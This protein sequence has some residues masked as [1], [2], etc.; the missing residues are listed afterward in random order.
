VRPAQA[1]AKFVAECRMPDAPFASSFALAVRREVARRAGVPPQAVHAADRLPEEWGDLFIRE[2][3]D[4]AEFVMELEQE[5]GVELPDAVGKLFSQESVGVGE[6]AAA[7]CAAAS[8][9]LRDYLT[10]EADF[11]SEGGWIGDNPDE[12]NPPGQQ[13]AVFLQET[14]RGHAEGITELWKEEG[15]GWAFNCEW[16]RVTINVLVQRPD[17]H[18]LVICSIVSLLPRFLR[19]RRYEMALSNLCYYLDGVVRADRRFRDVRW[20]TRAE[21]EDSGTSVGCDEPGAPTDRPRA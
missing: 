2:S 9:V 5:F 20:F 3:L 19:S 12:A 14:L 4:A 1:D 8:G 10:C 16:D 11:P 21:Y 7:L 15:Y 17:D 13:L 6:L 18:W